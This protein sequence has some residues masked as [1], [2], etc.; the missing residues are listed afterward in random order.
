MI[1]SIRKLFLGK[2]YS[3][4]KPL[5]SAI[6]KRIKNIVAIWNNE[7]HED[8]GIEKILRLFLAL[9]QFLFPG[10]YIKQ[11]FC[12]KGAAHQDLSM[13]F[14]ILFKVGFPVFILKNNLQDNHF[15][16]WIVVWLASETILYIPTL[17]FASDNFSRPRSYRRS[18]LLLFFNYMEIVFA[19]G[20]IYAQGDYL[21][22]PLVHWFD[23][24]YFS[25]MTSS[26]IGFGDMYPITPFGKFLVSC[27]SMF[28]LIFVVLFLNFFTKK[29]D[30]KGYFDHNNKL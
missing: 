14:F 10:I 20:V 5:E 18:M 2:T 11:V 8:I 30:H 12:K 26:T 16:F 23:S 27:Q 13:D 1:H 3:E 9:S 17:I 7:L 29:I 21:N 15:I 19:F 22:K 24:I 28:F 25:F 4:T 6:G